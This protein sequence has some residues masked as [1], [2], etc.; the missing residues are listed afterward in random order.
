[1][2]EMRWI[3]NK[4]LFSVISNEVRNLIHEKRFLLTAFVEMTLPKSIGH[5]LHHMIYDIF[6][7][8]F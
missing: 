4:L 5:S 1:M 7:I 6:S 2:E 3:K 8:Y